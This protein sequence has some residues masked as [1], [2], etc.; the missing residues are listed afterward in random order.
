MEVMTMAEQ[1]ELATQLHEIIE[2]T[3]TPEHYERLRTRLRDLAKAEI[4]RVRMAR[5]A[6]PSRGDHRS[7]H[8][9]LDEVAQ[10]RELQRICREVPVLEETLARAGFGRIVDPT[11]PMAMTPEM[12]RVVQAFNRMIE[13]FWEEE[14]PKRRKVIY[15]RDDLD[16][17]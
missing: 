4:S 8:N 1:L 10:F 5:T 2:A 9:V 7:G 12:G 13:E 11:N 3:L 16:P 6:S 15:T 14:M 17:V